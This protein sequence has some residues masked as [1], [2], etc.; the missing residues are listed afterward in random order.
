MLYAVYNVG[1]RSIKQNN[2]YKFFRFSGYGR[3]STIS[4]N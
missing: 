1:I 4:K 3:I 2:I